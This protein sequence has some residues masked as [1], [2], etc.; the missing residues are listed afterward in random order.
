MS[1]QRANVKIAWPNKVALQIYIFP[2]LMIVAF[3]ATTSFADGPSATL[4]LSGTV[5]RTVA[6]NVTP[7]NNY[8][9]LDL[10][11]GEAE[12]T[13]AIVNERSNDKAGYTVILTSAGSGLTGQ[14]LLQPS[15]PGNPDTIP[16]S[17]KYGGAP[18]VLNHGSATL[19]AASGRTSSTG[20]NNSL[21]VT[22]PSSA[23][24]NAD[25][26]SDTL[27]LTIQGN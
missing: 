2:L 26:Y 8:N 12:K 5:S 6:I 24:V 21:T 23:G 22:I 25:S 7:Q 18:V 3:I 20:N 4:T 11:G 15:T 16:Y 14:A 1:Q 27:Q 9:S 17:L 10:V 19:T 13:V